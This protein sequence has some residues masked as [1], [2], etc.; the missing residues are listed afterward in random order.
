MRTVKAVAPAVK[1]LGGIVLE[2]YFSR[3]AIPPNIP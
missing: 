1:I 3:E 2:G